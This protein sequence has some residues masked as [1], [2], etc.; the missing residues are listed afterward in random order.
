MHAN[1]IH[2]GY[3]LESN[4]NI[5]YS[6]DELGTKYFGEHNKRKEPHGKVINLFNNGGT[7]IIKFH[8]HSP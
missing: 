3:G 5:I 2:M 1:F 6:V 7:K 8:L 4:A